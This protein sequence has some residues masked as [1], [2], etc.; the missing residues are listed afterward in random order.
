MAKE[1][2]LAK[3]VHFG[4]HVAKELEIS[5]VGRG[6]QKNGPQGPKTIFFFWPTSAF[7]G[8]IG[9]NKA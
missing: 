4:Q 7:F 9:L 1:T 5:I 2:F 3:H 6:I 8:I